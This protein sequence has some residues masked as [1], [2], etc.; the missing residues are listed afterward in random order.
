MLFLLHFRIVDT[1]EPRYSIF[2]GTGQH[3][4]LNLDSLYCQY[5]NNYENTCWNQNLYALLAELS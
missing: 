4:A 2:Q 3:R 1:V 5:V